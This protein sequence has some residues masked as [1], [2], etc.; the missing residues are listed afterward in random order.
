M[1][2]RLLLIYAIVELAVVI[3]LVS[4]IGAGWTVLVLLATFVLGWAVAAPMAGSQLIHQLVQLRSEPREPQRA[5][6]DGALLTLATG[7][8]LV[9]GLVTTA[10]GVL[11]LVPAVRAIVGPGLAAVTMR[12]L[13]RRAPL[14]TPVAAGAFTGRTRRHRMDD[15][16]DFI[17][18]EVIDVTE[19]EPPS[20]PRVPAA[21]RSA[22][23]SSQSPHWIGP[24]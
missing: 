12:G 11:L 18:G 1:L 10:L 22:D 4:T 5:L 2:R 15:R 17:D 14:I 21:N 16:D 24:C 23:R 9:P 8:V 3:T 6:S 7:L 13:Q 20:L 19:A